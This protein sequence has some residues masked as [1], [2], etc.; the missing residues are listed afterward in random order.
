M[1]AFCSR[2]TMNKCTSRALHDFT[3]CRFAS[4][5]SQQHSKHLYSHFPIDFKVRSYINV[6][7]LKVAKFRSLI[8][9][10]FPLRVVFVIKVFLIRENAFQTDLRK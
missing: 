3:T 6:Y 7:L 9:L 2:S 4:P 8:P 1:L 10:S 5:P